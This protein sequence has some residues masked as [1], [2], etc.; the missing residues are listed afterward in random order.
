MSIA[1]R[2]HSSTWV[3]RSLDNYKAMHEKT[4]KDKGVA[5]EL[6]NAKTLTQAKKIVYGHK[7]GQTR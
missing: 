2:K 7:K 5:H 1:D 3:G 4:A 6:A